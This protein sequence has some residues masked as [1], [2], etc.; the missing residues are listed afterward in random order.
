MNGEKSDYLG[1]FSLKYQRLTYEYLISVVLSFAYLF[2]IIYTMLNNQYMD[3]YIKLVLLVMNL[4]AILL[5]NMG[6]RRVY[7]ESI[8]DLEKKMS[9]LMNV[10]YPGMGRDLKEFSLAMK[11]VADI[12]KGKKEEKK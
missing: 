6:M 4:F 2:V 7:M 11:E 9:Q 1:Y 10:Y 5:F 8:A 3:L 12:L